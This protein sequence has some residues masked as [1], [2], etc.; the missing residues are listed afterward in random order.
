MDKI[1]DIIF[2]G[3]PHRSTNAVMYLRRLL[4]ITYIYPLYF[5]DPIDIQ[6]TDLNTI[7]TD[8]QGRTQ[9]LEIVSMAKLMD[10]VTM[11]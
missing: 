5:C 3:S 4:R 8:F 11:E 7:I 2:I 9:K 6:F 10:L 1:H